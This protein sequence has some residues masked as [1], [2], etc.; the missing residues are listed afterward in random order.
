[1]GDSLSVVED[2]T[3]EGVLGMSQNSFKSLIYVIPGGS[4]VKGVDCDVIELLNE[5]S[6]RERLMVVEQEGLQTKIKLDPC[7]YIGGWHCKH[8]DKIPW[9]P[10]APSP[11]AQHSPMSSHAVQRRKGEKLICI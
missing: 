9:P 1:M 10:R 3:G 5:V 2:F 11:S 4:I 6:V 7:G 8:R